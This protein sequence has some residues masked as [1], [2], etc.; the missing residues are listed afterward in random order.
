MEKFETEI[1]ETIKHFSS[2]GFLIGDRVKESKFQVRGK[3]GSTE[4]AL[5]DFWVF[6]PGKFYALEC[7][8]SKDRFALS[9]IKPHQ[10]SNLQ[11]V[12]ANGG[13]GFFLLNFR[14]RGCNR[15]FVVDVEKLPSLTKK[16]LT[17][18]ACESFF[19]EVVRFVTRKTAKGYPRY[20]WDVWN[21]ECTKKNT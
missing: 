20:G 16:T 6:L 5:F 14:R 3:R 19:P 9:R 13:C 12:N 21:L 7:K 1:Y 8:R 17:V 2:S 15:T 11:F 18:E 4:P 10:L